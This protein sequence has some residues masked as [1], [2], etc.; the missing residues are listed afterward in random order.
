MSG[1]AEIIWSLRSRAREHAIALIFA[2]LTG[3]IILVP[4]LF[5]IFDPANDYQG[6]YVMT[7]DAEPFYL[8]RMQEYYDEGRVGNPFLFEHK[9]YGP[10]FYSYGAETLLA[11]PGKILGISVPTLGLIYKFILPALEFLLLYALIYRLT[12]EK[13]WA[14]GGALMVFLGLIWFEWEYLKHNIY[15]ATQSGRIADLWYRPEALY[16][17]RPV[18]PQFTQILL[19]LYL[20]TLLFIH[21]G[22]DV[23]WFIVLAGVLAYSFYAYF[24]SFT[25]FLA[26]NVV[27]AGLW[28]LGRRFELMKKMI[29]ATIFGLVIG[30]P[31]LW[32]I[33]AAMR[34]SEYARVAEALWVEESQEIILR[35]PGVILLLGLI[36]MLFWCRRKGI[37]QSSPSFQNLIF[38]LGLMLT[39]FIVVNQQLITGVEVQYVHYFRS[40]NNPIFAITLVS[41]FGVMVR[42]I[43]KKGGGPLATL[44]AK[45]AHLLSR[46][47]IVFLLAT[48]IYFQWAAYLKDVP[49]IRS[50]QRVMGAMH[51]L[52]ENTSKDDVIMAN[53]RLSLLIP[54]FAHNNVMWANDYIPAGFLVPSDRANFTPENLLKSEN[55]LLFSKKYRLNYILWDTVTNPDWDIGKYG[56]PKVFEGGKIE[57]YRLPPT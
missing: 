47:F 21:R 29:W 33:Y 4:Q 38:L 7:T 25:F 8:A 36:V 57:I 40:F 34:H 37:D 30:T 12:G 23:R 39:T 53:E 9:F 1:Y 2:V 31:P 13:E 54:L 41:L 24:F 17:G 5:F 55:P 35:L 14:I 49:A 10:M 56:L 11:I 6:L 27:F 52:R 44:F 28:I 46:A 20:N 26:L 3:L 19:A 43:G 51:W 22:K 45:F 15:Y 48:G 50:E 16:A 18:H 42:I 32:A